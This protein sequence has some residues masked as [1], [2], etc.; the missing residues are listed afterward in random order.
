MR[1]GEGSPR[2]ALRGDLGGTA[3]MLTS[4]HGTQSEGSHTVLS[5]QGFYRKNRHKE[6]EVFLTVCWVWAGPFP[7]GALSKRC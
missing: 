3:S 6:A 5:R 2:T 1:T 7:R 4:D